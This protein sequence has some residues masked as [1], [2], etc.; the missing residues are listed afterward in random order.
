MNTDTQTYDPSREPDGSVTL[1]ETQ[2]LYV[3]GHRSSGVARIV[4]TSDRA[5]AVVGGHEEF[6]EFEPGVLFMHVNI[7]PDYVGAIEEDWD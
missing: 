3:R 1:Y 4:P 2:D 6:G 7:A 5:K